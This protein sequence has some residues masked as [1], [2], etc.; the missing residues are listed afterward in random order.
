M[1]EIADYATNEKFKQFPG[2]NLWK[3]DGKWYRLFGLGITPN[4]CWRIAPG[5]IGL[6]DI[7][8]ATGEDV[9]TGEVVYLDACGTVP[10]CYQCLNGA[11]L[12]LY[13]HA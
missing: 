4:S 13:N 9:Y 2:L 5:M 8:I 11:A 3:K 7:D 6:K 1:T 10:P 12:N